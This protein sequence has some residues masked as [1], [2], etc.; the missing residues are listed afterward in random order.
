MANLFEKL[1]HLLGTITNLDGSESMRAL[2]S[3]RSELAR[4]QRIFMENNVNH[5]NGYN[6]LFKQGKV[7]EPI[8]HLFIISDEFAELK[9][10]QPEFMTELVSTARVGRSLGIHLILATQKPGGVVT[11]QIWTNSRFKLALKVQ[12]EADSKEVIKTADA[13]SITQ[14][15]RAYL[16]VGNNEIYELFQS[17]YSG[18][19][20]FCEEEVEMIDNRVY[21]M[22][23]F[24]QAELVNEDLSQL[25]KEKSSVTQLD[26]TVLAIRKL[27]D[28]MDCLEVKKPWLPS[29]QQKII[30]PYISEQKT[31]EFS[32]MTEIDS[33]IAIGLIDIPE[34]QCQKEYMH[35][36]LVDG[37][38]AIFGMAGFGKSTLIT[39]ILLSLS[40]KNNP[41]LLHYYILDMGNSALISLKNLPHTADYF[42]FEDTIKLKKFYSILE[43]KLK[44]RKR[45]FAQVGAMNIEMYNRIS[46]VVMP[47]I[48]WV[49]DNFDVNKEMDADL[50]GFVTQ[51][52]RDGLSLGI[53][54]I[55]ASSRPGVLRFAL[56][57]SF[58]KKIALFMHDSSELSGVVGRGNFAMTEVRGRALVKMDNVNQMQVFLAISANTD[59]EYVDKIR[60]IVKK[61]SDSYCGEPIKGIPML[62]EKLTNNILSTYHK[63]LPEYF[64]PIG[65][66]IQDV[67]CQYLDIRKG[68]QLI[69]GGI[70]SGRT[71]LLKLVMKNRKDTV[72]TY[73]IDDKS[74]EL[75]HFRN[76]KNVNY[77]SNK[78]GITGF[79][80]ELR[81][82]IEDRNNSFFE[83]QQVN[84][85]LIPR[86]YFAELP[87]IMVL[88]SEW[89]EFLADL[90]SLK[91]LT[92]ETIIME[93]TKVNI[94]L[95]VSANVN[96]FKGFDVLTKFLKESIYGVVTGDI[97]AQSVFSMNKRIPVDN[98]AG[99]GYMINKGEI[100][101]IQIAK[102]NEIAE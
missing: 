26:A 90:E 59:I 5:I 24:G 63:E 60:E 95:I 1:P 79:L 21:Y 83:E 41:E 70:Q 78:E 27:Y 81:C 22:N 80:N 38:L 47:A 8:P 65:L 3:I 45:L 12:N 55:I 20:F 44:E 42:T 35:D 93:A 40:E 71:N 6:L 39:T 75:Y 74:A 16:Q 34:E 56:A 98:S 14:P 19:E 101:K 85:E 30:S 91:D 67:T 94:A 31:Y 86:I 25:E 58:K 28:S 23:I 36:F 69:L 96:R 64:I 72:K 54:V 100:S 92:A 66:D 51:I 89:E 7:K 49:I 43:E 18:A 61:M 10:E 2:A 33:K 57:N 48:V 68:K 53:Y 87:V 17:A 15:G 46:D 11:D 99:I 4:R 97:N 62:P 76:S 29:L 88:I 32:E 82:I 9:K 52:A 13:A 37:N 84:H 102:I 73:L 50:E 77:I